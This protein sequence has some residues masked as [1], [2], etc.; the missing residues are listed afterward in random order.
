MAVIS[1]DANSMRRKILKDEKQHGNEL[2]SHARTHART[3]HCGILF[4]IMIMDIT[5]IIILLLCATLSFSKCF[6]I[7][8]YR[9]FGYFYRVAVLFYVFLFCACDFLFILLSPFTCLFVYSV[10]D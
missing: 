2:Y 8:Y 4:S 6:V 5:L 3:R 1:A 9:Y 7:I 10:I